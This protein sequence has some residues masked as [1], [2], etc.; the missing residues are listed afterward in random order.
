MAYRSTPLHNGYSPSE[1]LM[2]RKIRTR[3]P[4]HEKQLKPK[5]PNLNKI[6]Q[7]EQ[8]IKLKQKH[9][10]D[11]RHRVKALPELSPGEKVWVKDQKKPGF[12]KSEANTHRSYFVK[13]PEG[14]IRRNRKDL[15]SEE[16]V[17]NLDN[18]EQCD[19]REIEKNVHGENVESKREIAIERTTTPTEQG[20]Y[21]VTR[22]G[23]ISKPPDKLNL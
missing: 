21:Y 9:N 2:G 16:N 22:S 11:R 6:K 4:V 7:K 1:L 20:K 15:I 8:K 18:Q 14:E 10:Y 19:F 3:V 12:V 17:K 13:T 5:W 23:R